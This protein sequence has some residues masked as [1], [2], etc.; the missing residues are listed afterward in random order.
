MTEGALPPQ[1]GAQVPAGG[2]PLR[3]ATGRRGLLARLW[4]SE[5][6]TALVEFALVAPILFLLVFGIVEFG[7]VL[8][9]YN[10]LTQLSGQ[11]AR[12]AA[13]SR[14]PDGTPVG[15]TSGT[16]DSTCNG[17]TYSIQCQLS[18]YY[19]Q[20][21]SLSGVSV[22]IPAVAA[23]GQPVTVRTKYVY[24]FTVGLFGFAHITL[25]STQTERSEATATYTPGD[26]TG[27]TGGSA[28][29]P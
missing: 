10:D 2:E 17:H 12:A 4:R 14:N 1:P 22:C 15:A 27:S 11:G 29:S 16:I 9:A 25:S 18:H 6:G 3:R 21:D 5:R 28:C 24:N 19:A 26:E 20:T 23:P 8:N 13:V 7:R